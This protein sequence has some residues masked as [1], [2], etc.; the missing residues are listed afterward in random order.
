MSYNFEVEG[1]KSIEL[2]TQGQYCPENIVV[3]AKEEDLSDELNTQKTLLEGLENMLSGQYVF[4]RNTATEKQEITCSSLGLTVKDS[5]NNNL[6]LL[7]GAFSKGQEVIV[8]DMYFI[9]YNEEYKQYHS[10]YAANGSI[11]LKGLSQ[12]CG[13]KFTDSNL[14]KNG[15][16]LFHL[17]SQTKKILLSN[18]SF[19]TDIQLT[20]DNNRP[21]T[22]FYA[23]TNNA[24]DIK[25]DSFK[26][27]NCVF[28]GP[29]Q[30]IVFESVEE[31]L[32]KDYGITDL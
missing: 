30:T 23:E 22:L 27:E 26:I 11:V 18:I 3:T 29:I 6:K 28:D 32:E 17:T 19:M 24:K 10:L 14:F 12:M 25:I 5:N 13:F 21:L 4:P 9:N 20:L 7:S 16:S 2:T 31:V 15:L 1:G 8:D